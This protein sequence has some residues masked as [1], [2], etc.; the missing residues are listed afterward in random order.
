MTVAMLGVIVMGTVTM[1]GVIAMGT[2]V[3]MQVTVV[4]CSVG[5]NR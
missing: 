3:T 2:V 1:L 4:T 5:V